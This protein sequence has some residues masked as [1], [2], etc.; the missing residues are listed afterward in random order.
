MFGQ[1]GQGLGDVDANG[2]PCQVAGLDFYRQDGEWRMSGF[3]NV[4][5][6]D[7][8]N[9][10]DA[11]DKTAKIVTDAC[12]AACPALWERFEASG[13]RLGLD[14]RDDTGFRDYSDLGRFTDGVAQ[15]RNDLRIVDEFRQIAADAHAGVVDVVARADCREV[16][17][18]TIQWEAPYHDT[19]A[20]HEIHG[21]GPRPVVGA[22][23]DDDAVVGYAVSIDAGGRYRDVTHR[24][25]LLVPAGL[26][27]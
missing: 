17:P 26:V 25:P 2:I 10:A 15:L 5:R 14:V 6:R 19:L 13:A 4:R 3:R 12:Q 24:G 22:V 8:D 21:H 9:V 7:T 16:L 18:E 23:L 11:P 20:G 27:R 1:F